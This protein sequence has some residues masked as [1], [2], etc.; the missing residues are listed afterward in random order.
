MVNSKSIRE[1]RSSVVVA[2]IA[3]L[4]GVEGLEETDVGGGE[5]PVVL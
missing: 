5:P 4:P 1:Q 3:A 2:R